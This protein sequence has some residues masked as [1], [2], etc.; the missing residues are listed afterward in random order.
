MGWRG[1]WNTCGGG[2]PPLAGCCG[3]GWRPTSGGGRGA[4]GHP[5]YLEHAHLA[6][7]VSPHP[8][9][10]WPHPSN[11]PKMAQRSKLLLE[12]DCSTSC[13]SL[14]VCPPELL[15]SRW[16]RFNKSVLWWKVCSRVCCSNPSGSGE[17]TRCGVRR[18]L[19]TGGSRVT[20]YL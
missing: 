17:C 18:L 16:L 3:A 9:P 13:K 14:N 10:Y 12:P 1:C 5:G 15:W 4:P 11:W 8:S 6:A 7:R 20:S 2:L 19:P